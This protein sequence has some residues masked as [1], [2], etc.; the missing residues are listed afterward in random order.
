MS[1]LGTL[2]LWLTY[3][4]TCIALL[5]IFFHKRSAAGHAGI[6]AGLFAGA[7]V[8]IVAVLLCF[9]LITGI[10]TIEYVYHNTESSLPLIYKISAFW[11]GSAGSMLLWTAFLAVLLFICYFRYKQEPATKTVSGVLLIFILIF[12]TMITF[13]NNPFNRV[14]PATDG[15]GLNPALQSLGM[16]FHPPV[17]IAG[18]ACF[19]VALAYTFYDLRQT[20]ASHASHIRNWALLGWVLL[21]I[22]II[23]GGLWAYTELGWGG[24]WAWDP[25]EN[26]SLVNWLLATIFLHGLS[27]KSHLYAQRK[28]RNL[29]WMA[30]TVFSTLIGTFIARSGILRSVHAY[31]NQHV[32]IFFGLILIG[33]TVLFI[34]LYIRYALARPAELANT[35]GSR[36]KKFMHPTNVLTLLLGVMALAV[37]AGTVSP[38]FGIQTPIAFYDYTFAIFGLLLLMLLGV[39]P[40]LGEKKP[41]RLL[42]GLAAGVI[43]CIGLI[44]RTRLGLFTIIALAVCAMLVFH[45]LLNIGLQY[46]SL[47][48]SRARVA[49]LLLHGALLF[50]AL[51][52]SF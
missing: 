19:F 8:I 27:G 46:K 51:G 52:I 48:T 4:I 18:F 9:S 33:L 30:L 38:L 26:S 5:L 35:P 36:L 45:F 12:L 50:L 11:S 2:L 31:S 15:F 29:I 43:V 22:G 24:Y 41:L 34:F 6:I 7:G 49:S 14:S 32:F 42:P 23:R 21:T 47:F 28:R 16:V 1:E 39:S 10:F 25:I 3:G 20:A 40:M 13:I 17:V 44:I 37:F